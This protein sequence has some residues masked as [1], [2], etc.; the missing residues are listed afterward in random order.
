MTFLCDRGYE[1]TAPSGVVLGDEWSVT[2]QASA[3]GSASGTGS[4]GG[5]TSSDIGDIAWSEEPQ[6]FTCTSKPNAL[7]TVFTSSA[8]AEFLSSLPSL[9]LFS[10]L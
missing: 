9:F 10:Q 8:V 7:L 6:Q 5:N 4:A 3:T 1:L 2:C